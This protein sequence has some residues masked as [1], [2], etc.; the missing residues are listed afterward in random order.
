MSITYLST[1][2]KY[3]FIYFYFQFILLVHI[4]VDQS[5]LCYIRY[6]ILFLNY[7]YK[8]NYQSYIFTFITKK[9]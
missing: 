5:N 4:Y 9:S 8:K 3:L 1:G 7:I 6:V 2:V